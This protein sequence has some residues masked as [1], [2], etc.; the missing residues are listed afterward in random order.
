MQIKKKN[1]KVTLWRSEINVHPCAGGGPRSDIRVSRNHV[2]LSFI[3]ASTTAIA[4]W[5]MLSFA[6]LPMAD[7]SCPLKG[8]FRKHPSKPLIGLHPA[9]KPLFMATRYSLD[10]A[11]CIFL[12]FLGNAKG[13]LDASY[14]LGI[15]ENNHLFCN[16]F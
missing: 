12:L 6:S 2:Q 8:H 7:K 14:G 5:Y 1:K 10:S 3:S 16:T 11:N 4:T 15:M 13:S 9:M